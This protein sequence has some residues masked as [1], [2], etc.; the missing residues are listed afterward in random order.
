MVQKDTH[1]TVLTIRPHHLCCLRF[2][3]ITH[4]ERGPAF[5]QVNSEIKEL[6]SRPDSAVMVAEGTD[7]LCAKC[8]FIYEGRCTRPNGGEDEVRK[9]DAILLRELGVPFG[10]CMTSG[11]WHELIKRKIPFQL[12]RRCRWKPT[13]SVGAELL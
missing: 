9:W 13:C 1:T 3:Q 8:T 4:G 10:S 12:C 5:L 11:E 6:L 7:R 2:S